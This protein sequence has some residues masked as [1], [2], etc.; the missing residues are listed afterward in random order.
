MRRTAAALTACVLTFG[1]VSCGDNGGDTAATST[2]NPSEFI[3][4][5]SNKCEEEVSRV[6]GNTLLDNTM[7]AVTATWGA[8]TEL[9]PMFQAIY[10]EL[11]PSFNVGAIGI[12][13]RYISEYSINVCKDNDVYNTVLGL[14]AGDAGA[15]DGCLDGKL[16]DV[17][18][19]LADCT[20]GNQATT[21]TTTG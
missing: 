1:L 21:T 16:P 5:Y 7:D 20:E 4:T 18:E 9:V 15:R 14:D 11:K 2:T 19:A 8:G 3:P 17:N 12:G 13:I 6:I 10:D